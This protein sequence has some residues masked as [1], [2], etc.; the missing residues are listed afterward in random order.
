MLKKDVNT[1]I[2]FE[3]TMFNPIKLGKLFFIDT[4]SDSKIVSYHFELE[5]E[6]V[7]V[8]YIENMKVVDI[9]IVTMKRVQ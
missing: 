9:D 4:E 7:I 2:V 6:D 1:N 5:N 8:L 3:N